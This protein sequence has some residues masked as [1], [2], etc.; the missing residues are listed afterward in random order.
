MYS[1]Y[2]KNIVGNFCEGQGFQ[3]RAFFQSLLVKRF[4]I[5]NIIN[6]FKTKCQKNAPNSHFSIKLSVDSGSTLKY[7]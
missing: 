7:I 4:Y 5:S 1:F 3:I 6:R 2:K